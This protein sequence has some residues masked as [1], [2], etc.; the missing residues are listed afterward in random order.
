MKWQGLLNSTLKTHWTMSEQ[1]KIVSIYYTKPGLTRDASGESLPYRYGVWVTVGG[2]TPYD[3]RGE[4][5][6]E[7]IEWDSHVKQFKILFSGGFKLIPYLPD[8][9]IVYE[10]VT[11]EKKKNVSK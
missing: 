9:E 10:Y 2:T 6:V 7:S 11:T 5:K 4:K 8:T 1:T 3:W